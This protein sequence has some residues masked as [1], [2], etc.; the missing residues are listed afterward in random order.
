MLM[1]CEVV[2]LQKAMQVN[3]T[4][5]LQEVEVH[6]YKVILKKSKQAYFVHENA[7]PNTASGL[8]DSERWWGVNSP[9]NIPQS[10]LQKDQHRTSTE[11]I[12]NKV[13]G[14]I[15]TTSAQKLLHNFQQEN[16]KVK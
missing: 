13:T 15:W 9:L 12:H 5:Q 2:P 4:K 10:C 3:S 6:E 1:Q 7:R 14:S 8:L 16:K 11:L